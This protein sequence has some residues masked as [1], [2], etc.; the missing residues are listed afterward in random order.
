MKKTF[1]IA[2]REFSA[3]FDSLIAYIL[4]SLFLGLSGF[5]TWISNANIFFLG[6]ASLH[7]FFSVAYWT[8]FFFIPSLTMRTLSEEKR[9]GTL[10][11]LCTKAIYDWEIVIGKWLACVG[12]I[13]V[14]LICT[15]PYYL[16][17]A[18]LGPIDHGA[19]IGG[20]CALMA[21]SI[22]YIGI[23]T[24]VSS[25]TNNQIVAF[26]LTLVSCFCFQMLFDT[27]GGALQ[28]NVALVLHYLSASTH[29]QSMARGVLDLRD[30]LY[31]ASIAAIGLWGAQN[32]LAKRLN[33]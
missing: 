17:A 5:F 7:V 25:T 10:E 9:N 33:A 29:F 2:Q 21:L 11:M 16:S 8:L 4:V 12:L 22:A 15:L 24:W 28:G 26:L 30:L 1:V 23:G 18:W 19:V 6:Q 14:A 3:F 20:Y 27:L 32:T 31:F 13:L